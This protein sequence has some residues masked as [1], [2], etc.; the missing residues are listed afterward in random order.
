MDFLVIKDILVIG[1]LDGN[2][3]FYDFNTKKILYGFG[4][5]QSGGIQ[6]LYTNK[7]SS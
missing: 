4:A 5:Q 6:K 7:D 3:L 1:C 2:L